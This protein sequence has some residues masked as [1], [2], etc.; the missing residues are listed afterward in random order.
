M[1]QLLQRYADGI[2]AMG[3]RERIMFF[4]A[5]TLV[6]VTLLQVFL[7]DPVLSRRNLLSTQIVQQED[8]TKAILAKIQTLIRPDAPDQD[9]LNRDRLKSLRA[10]MELLDRQFE[11][12]QRQFVA[13]AK[14]AA[15][16]E[17]MIAKNRNLKLIS[18]RNLPATSLTETAAAA[19]A[20]GGQARAPGAHEVFR[21]GLELSI[22][23]SYFDL[24]DYLVA[25]EHMPQQVFYDGFDLRAGQYPQSVLTLTIYTLSPE[26]SWLTV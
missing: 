3:L 8:E 22:S 16:L 26:K 4:G 23:G 25:L 15:V 20:T 24:L 11:Q 21:H 2:D 17:S 12:Q 5:V 19:G 14:M 10:E 13:P 1:R 7:L 18:L 6:M 9:A